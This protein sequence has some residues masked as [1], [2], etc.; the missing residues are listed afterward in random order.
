MTIK[1][2]KR[3]I[4]LPIFFALVLIAGIYLGRILTV[5]GG[6]ITGNKLLIYP[7][8]NKLDALINLIKDEYVD[9]VNTDKLVESV[10]PEI[11]EQLD[12]HTVYIPAKDLQS[13]NEELEGNF[14]GI[15]VQFS[16]QKDTVLVISVISGGPSEKVGILA[17]DRIVTVN[18]SII[19]GVNKTSTDVMNM[20]RGEIGTKVAVGV[21]RRNLKTPL[22]FEIT[23]DL[24][25]VYSVDVSYMVNKDVGLIKV[26]RFAR[27]TYDEFI[28]AIAKLKA[29]NCKKIIIDLRGDTGGFLDIAFNMINEF[30]SKNEMIVYTEGKASPRQEMRANGTGTCQDTKVA[31]LMDEFSASASEIFAGAIQDNDRGIIVGR[32]SFGKGLV[33]EQIPLPDGSAIRLTIARYYTPSG[34]CIQK[35][36]DNGIDDYYH[37]IMK[38]YEHGEFY[39]KDSIEVID[40]LAYK[41]K[42]GRTVYGGGGIM[43]DI[44]IP[45]DTSG[46]TP[47][48]YSLRERGIIY[49]FALTYSDS[50]RQSLSKL[51]T[52]EEFEEKLK[53]EVLMPQLIELGKEKGIKYNAEQYKISKPYIITEVK[54]Y[55]A[56][57]I[58]DNDGFYPILFKNDDMVLAA[59]KELEKIEPDSLAEK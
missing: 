2:T 17:G 4:L 45:R 38:R 47:Y 12:P 39:E 50:H 31:V 59:V 52:P 46:Y 8:T 58:I 40:S 34:R 9:T 16:M 54:A 43:P 36:Y 41:T 32:R 24:I 33:Q 57:N 55:I 15:G 44:F 51:T 48:Y 11:L 56:R 26:N 27:T 21:L 22:T 35:S 49:Q 29:H 6:G 10:I 14:G 7:Q 5:Q 37:D 13:V 23:R 18:D 3:Q 28:T 1:N 19:A 20:L 30:L 25:P 42:N 53:E